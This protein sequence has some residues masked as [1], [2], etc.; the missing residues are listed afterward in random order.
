MDNLPKANPYQ[1]SIGE[2]FF[3]FG[4][5]FIIFEVPSIL[6]IYIFYL[7]NSEIVQF[8]V[9]ATL[10]FIP[11]FIL[12]AIMLSSWQQSAIIYSQISLI[13]GGV[14]GLLFCGVYHFRNLDQS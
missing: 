13:Y 4:I 6:F 12:M 5:E 2:L 9:I 14:C 11:V 7:Q 1:Y 3:L 8:L 10:L